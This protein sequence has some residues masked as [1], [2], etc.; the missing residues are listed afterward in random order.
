MQLLKQR[1]REEGVVKKG[2]VLK[3]DSFLNHRI[4][5]QL[6][7]AIGEEFYRLFADAGVTKIVTIEA[8]GIGV[9]VMAARYFGVPVV[10]AKKAKTAQLDDEFYSARIH[11]FTHNNDYTAII[12]RKYLSAEDTVLVIDDFLANGEATRGL[13]TILDDAGAK[14]AG[15]GIVIEKG[16]QGGGDKLRAE[17]IRVESLALID[18]MDWETGEIVFRE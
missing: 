9:A 2:N 13:L 8:S 6:L 18:S 12:S 1:I 10:F 4:D 11:S 17:G 14:L 7:D 5:T 15:V 16:F 3:V